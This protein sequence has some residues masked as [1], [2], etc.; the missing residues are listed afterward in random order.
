MMKTQSLLWVLGLAVM[1]LPAPAGATR[2]SFGVH[3]KFVNI[4]FESRMD[5]EDIFGST[6][7]ISGWLQLTS[8]NNGSFRL[9]VPVES[10]K[11]GIDL[12]DEHLRSETWLNAA[13]YPNLLFEGNS[14]RALG[15]NRY[16][17]TGTFSAHG[18]KKK[19]AVV[20]LATPIPKAKAAKLGLGDANWVRI[21]GSFTINL[22]DYGIKIPKMAAAKVN[23]QW[24][25]K[26][27]LFAK[28]D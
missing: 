24:T 26:V 11:T 18:K 2:Y 25:V 15:N 1:A 3:P 14:L 21:R 10:L 28:E 5:I 16:K 17:V 13:K 27:S 8:K 9:E 6:H 12:R 4:S 22:K 7:S 23:D 20:V 19:L